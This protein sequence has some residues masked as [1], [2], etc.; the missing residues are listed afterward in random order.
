[1]AEHHKVIIIGSGPAG[2][3]AAIYTARASLAPLVLEGMEPGGQLTTTTEVENFPGFD[4]GI[5]GPELIDK[6]RAQAKRFG[7][8]C[9]F[10][11]IESVDFSNRPFKLKSDDAEYTADTVIISTGASAKYLGLPSELALIGHGVSG[12]A[13][14]DGFFFKEKEV[15]VVGGGDSAMEEAMFLT[16]FAT[17]V[18]ILYRGN[19]FRASKIMQDRALA[20]PKIEV[21]WNSLPIEVLGNKETGV[22]G[23]KLQDTVTQEVSDFPVQGMFLGIGHKPNTDPFVGQITLDDKGYIL[24][25]PG[26]PNTNIEGVFACGDVQD[27]HYRQAITAAGSGCMA[28]IDAEKYLEALESS[29]HAV[30]A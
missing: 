4:E 10:E 18:T 7:A 25:K 27:T 2:L 8:T 29:Q 19:K 14:C 15:C 6:M 23:L 22:T 30:S 12:C 20:H 16:R 3:T 24:T 13:T 26:T 21:K 1:M 17:K 5:Q 28:A 11:T 9:K